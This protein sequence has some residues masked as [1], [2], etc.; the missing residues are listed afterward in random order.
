MPPRCAATWSTTAISI[1][2]AASTGVRVVRCGQS[3]RSVCAID[4]HYDR[5]GI[6]PDASADEVR[7]A[8]RRLARRYHP[9]ARGGVSSPEMAEIN[10]AWRALS[11]PGRRAMY[12]A[13]LRSPAAGSFARAEPVDRLQEEHYPVTPR[14]AASGPSRFPFGPLAGLVGGAMVL[15][16]VFSALTNRG[17]P[18]D[19]PAV[20]PIMRQGDCIVVEPNTDARKVA[21]DQPNDGVVTSFIPFDATCPFG[22]EPHRD[23]QGMGI[24][25]VTIGGG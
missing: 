19:P 20:D 3:P 14:P 4:T 16:F 22:T 12:D 25:C 2:P 1:V 21:C 6:R 23:R 24:A 17:D 8:Y 9:D 18:A 15:G 11:D 10:A 13:S 5:L 7:E